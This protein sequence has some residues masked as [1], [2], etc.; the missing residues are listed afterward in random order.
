[1]DTRIKTLMSDTSTRFSAIMH[2]LQ[3]EFICQFSTWQ[4]ILKFFIAFGRN[5]NIEDLY[6]IT[7]HRCW[8]VFTLENEFRPLSH[9]VLPQRTGSENN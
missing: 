9:Q 2:I 6:V 4:M 5:C 7:K 3:I 1:M 8:V